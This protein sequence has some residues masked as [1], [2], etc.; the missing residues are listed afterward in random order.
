MYFFYFKLK[1][2]LKRMKKIAFAAFMAVAVLLTASCGK[3][4]G[5]NGSSVE[6]TAV[7]GTKYTITKEITSDKAKYGV[8]VGNTQTIE[9]S[10]ES[11]TY[12]HGFFIADYISDLG[13]TILSERVLL[14][15]KNG[16]TVMTSD[17]ITYCE[18]G[19]FIGKM[20]DKT[21]VYFP[22]TG[23]GFYALD[24]YAISGNVIL[25]KGYEDWGA[26]TTSNDTILGPHYKQIILL[27]KGK[28]RQYLIQEDGVWLRLNA[29]GEAIAQVSAAE[30]KKLKKQGG[31]QKDA[32]AFVLKK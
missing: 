32:G 16:K 29:Q 19:Y 12:F 30:M 25:A 24:G 7:Q 14:D 11:M 23:V 26:Y 15:P 8:K 4:S 21:D 13:G 22:E 20:R 18:E 10:Y 6:E 27:E 1:L 3:T 9:N 5:T 28:E 17:T 31:W 2:N